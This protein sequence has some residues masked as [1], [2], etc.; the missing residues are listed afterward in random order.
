M[1]RFDAPFVTL[2]GRN[3]MGDHTS[4]ILVLLVPL[5]WVFP[6]AGT[7]FFAQALV[8]GPGA[9]PV[10]LYA[11]RRL[12]SEAMALVLA[13]AYLLHPA[14]G[15]TNLENFHPDAF[16][17]VLVGTAIWAALERHW[18]TYAV[19]VVLA[20]LVKEDVALVV[21]LDLGRPQAG[22]SDRADHDH[23]QHQLHARGDAGR[24]A[25]AH[26]RGRPQRL[27]DPVR[28]G[29]RVRRDDVPPSRRRDRPL[30]V[31]RAPLVRVADAD[32][33]RLRVPAPAERGAHRLTG[34]RRQRR[35]DVL[36][37]VPHPVP[38]LAGGGSA[39]GD[40]NGLRCRRLRPPGAG[41]G[42]CGRGGPPSY[43]GVLVGLPPFSCYGSPTGRPAIPWPSRCGELIDGIPSDAGVSA[44]HRVTPHL[45]HRE[46]I[47]QFPNPFR[48]VL[49]GPDISLE[50]TRLDDLADGVE[51]VVLPVAKEPDNQEDWDVIRPGPSISSSRTRRGSCGAGPTARSRRSPT[52]Q[53]Y[54][55][56]EGTDPYRLCSLTGRSCVRIRC[57]RRRRPSA[58]A[59]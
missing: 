52:D 16:I 14:V 23:R 31:G 24:H 53:P 54:R 9:V 51:Y 28:R 25:L 45:A 38:L 12:A 39:A 4:F 7:L 55:Q 21:V 17:G 46:K 57:R 56:S 3:L 33:V 13:A 29:R 37:P 26:R 40:R 1:S 19:F 41:G 59:R 22:P 18:R 11:R 47:Y 34:A 36:V 44:Y 20:L 2:M 42:R 49:Y 48:V 58:P 10:F 5:Y 27:A 35:V 15:W 8:I 30:P 50:G 43:H 6:A 32:A